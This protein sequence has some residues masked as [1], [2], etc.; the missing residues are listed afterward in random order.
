MFRRSPSESARASTYTARILDRPAL[1]KLVALAKE[2]ENAE[3]DLNRR[4]EPGSG[5]ASHQPAQ[6][7]DRRVFPI[8]DRRTSG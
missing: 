8:A 2:Q 4:R 5:P 7:G 3:G 1:R 6:Q